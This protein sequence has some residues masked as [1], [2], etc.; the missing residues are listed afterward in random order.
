M[1]GARLILCP[2]LFIV[3]SVLWPTLSA[4]LSDGSRFMRAMHQC[5]GLGRVSDYRLCPVVLLGGRWRKVRR[6]NERQRTPHP[7]KKRPA[8]SAPPLLSLRGPA[9][10]VS[11][12]ISPATR[13][14][15]A[16][17]S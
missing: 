16:A 3:A 11:I 1:E 14:V 13:L 5:S 2:F 4:H 8:S 7:R 10:A 17:A 12:Q 6:A 9:M 15:S